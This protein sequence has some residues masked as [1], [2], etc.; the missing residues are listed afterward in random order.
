MK[1]GPGLAA[2]LAAA[3]LLASCNCG[4]GATAS[5]EGTWKYRYNCASATAAQCFDQDVCSSVSFTAD[6]AAGAAAW[7]SSDGK[8]TG[9]LSGNVLTWKARWGDPPYDEVG[10]FVFAADFSS[11]TQTT[12]YTYD[13]V[14]DQATT[15]CT[16]NNRG[17]CT[18]TGA[19]ASPGPP[20]AVGACPAGAAASSCN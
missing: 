12:C 14:A 13:G 16:G 19:K 15:T 5:P 8:L 3:A 6:T 9:T 7:K 4:P 10:K 18:G 17:Q 20:A 1:T 2:L 11:F